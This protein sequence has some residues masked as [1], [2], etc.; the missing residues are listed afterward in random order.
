[1][2]VTH[3]SFILLQSLCRLLVRWDW[4]CTNS[5]FEISR[6]IGRITGVESK[7]LGVEI[8]GIISGIVIDS[9]V[10][11]MRG[12]VGRVMREK[13]IEQGIMRIV[14]VLK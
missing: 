2:G 13:F 4:N 9:M 10:E 14:G 5:I 12:E 7:Y 1:M 8:I 6:E 11:L 3:T